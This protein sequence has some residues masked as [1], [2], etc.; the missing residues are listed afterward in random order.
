M[1]YTLTLSPS[2]DYYVL[3]DNLKIGKINRS[4]TE[5]LRVGGKGINVS[6]V[7]KELEIESIPVLLTAGFTKDKILEDLDNYKFNYYNIEVNGINRINV[8]IQAEEETAINTNGLFINDSH[9]DLI[10]DYLKRLTKDDYLVIS[11]SIPSGVRRD[12]Y[13]YIISKLDYCNLNIVVDAEKDLLLNTLKY[14]P[15]LVK[16]NKEELEQLC[17]KKLKS[18]NDIYN[19]GCKL[20]KLG[21]KNVIVSLGEMGLLYIS[22]SLEKIYLPSIDVNV[23]STVGAG[24]SLIAGF[25]AGHSLNKETIDC[26]KLGLASACATVES[27]YLARKD[28]I[29]RKLKLIN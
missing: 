3:L 13:E 11:G 8:K 15:F 26:L 23:I 17:N 14:K 20:I 6:K 12:V 4:K 28:D 16:P 10:V 29:N 22:S 19:E 25:L 5:Y 18:I 1:I 27:A 7:L 24:D 9:I 2:I 21:A